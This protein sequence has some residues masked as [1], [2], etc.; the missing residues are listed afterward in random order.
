[1]HIQRYWRQKW[2]KELTREKSQREK[3]L[4][5]AYCLFLLFEANLGKLPLEVVAERDD[6]TFVVKDYMELHLPG[7]GS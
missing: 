5:P 4:L 3:I 1:M 7:I 2:E 6:V